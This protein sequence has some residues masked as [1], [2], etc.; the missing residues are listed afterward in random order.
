[1]AKPGARTSH[2]LLEGS[3]PRRALSKDTGSA[4]EGVKAHDEGV[5]CGVVAGAR[6]ADAVRAGGEVPVQAGYGAL[7]D[8]DAG[9]TG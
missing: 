7:G 9:C 2:K 4:E 8:G 5:N 3:A 6:E 1:M